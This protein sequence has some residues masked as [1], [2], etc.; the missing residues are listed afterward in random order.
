MSMF[1]YLLSKMLPI[2]QFGTFDI[3]FIYNLHY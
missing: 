1:N 2:E 3:D